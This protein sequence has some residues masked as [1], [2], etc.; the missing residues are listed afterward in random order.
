MVRIKSKAKKMTVEAFK[1]KI[2]DKQLHHQKR[3]SY[4]GCYSTKYKVFR[5]GTQAT[6]C[7]RD[8]DT[9]SNAD[10]KEMIISKI[11]F[12]RLVKE[13]TNLINEDIRF[14]S[15]AMT[16]IQLASERYMIDYFKEVQLCADHAN[17]M[18]ITPKNLKLVKRVIQ[19]EN[20]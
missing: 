8:Y 19:K 2:N 20:N 1:Q 3:T 17:Q 5:P 6:R 18:S 11:A 16:V 7:I 13:I 12:Q 14:Q 15:S 10:S 4:L 9:I